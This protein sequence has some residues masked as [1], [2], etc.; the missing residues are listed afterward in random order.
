VKSLRTCLFAAAVAVPLALAGCSSSGGGS[1]PS[2]TTP[3]TT[4][5]TSTA[6]ASDNGG[7]TQVVKGSITVYAASSLTGA[8][9]TLKSDFEKLYPGTSVTLTFGASSDLATQ[10]NQGA[11]VDVFASAA[12]KNM[13]Q[14]GANALQA[15]NFASNVAEIAVPAKNPGKITKLADLARSGVKVAV[16]APAVPC[17]AIATQVFKNAGIS[18]KPVAQ[19]SDVKH[20]LALAVSGEADAAVVYVTDVLSAGKSVKGITIPAADNASTEYPIARLKNAKN[21]AVAEAWVQYVLTP[22]AQKV[23]TADGFRKP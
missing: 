18:V 10:I 5:G 9:T 1:A 2:S 14:V 7:G 20:T 12:P 11:P 16:C 23:L 6:A 3:T 21:A 17:G 22:A 19:E 13:Q 4:A 8:F 15:Q